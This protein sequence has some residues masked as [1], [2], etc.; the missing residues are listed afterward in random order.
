M[1]GKSKPELKRMHEREKYASQPELKRMHEREKYASQPELKR[2]DEREK[3]ASQPELKR[4][5]ERN[6]LPNRCQRER[7]NYSNKRDI[8]KSKML[9]H[10]RECIPRFYCRENVHIITSQHR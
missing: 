4:K 1:R 10:Y 2:M 3:Y 7:L 6:I 8:R 9:I 5:V